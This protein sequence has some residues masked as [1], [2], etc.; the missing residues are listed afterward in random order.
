M[1]VAPPARLRKGDVESRGEHGRTTSAWNHNR[2]LLGLLGL[3]GL[4][5]GSEFLRSKPTS[6]TDR[7]DRCLLAAS[8]D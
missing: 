5:Q 1:G 7:R 4:R 8:L 6:G 3:L 2:R